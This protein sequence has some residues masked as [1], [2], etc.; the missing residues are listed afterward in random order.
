MIAVFCRHDRDFEELEPTPRKMFRRVRS[1]NDI[2]STK[3]TG[4]I[5]A[6]DWHRGGKKLTKRMTIYVSYSL[7]CLNS[8][9][10]NT[11]TQMSYGTVLCVPFNI[12]NT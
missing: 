1:I 7:S 4:I 9:A 11:D 3:F 6:H 10:H 12:L 8:I 5:R 2:R